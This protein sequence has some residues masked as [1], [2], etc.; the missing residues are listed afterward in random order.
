MLIP[1]VVIKGGGD[2]GTGVAHRLFR[3]AFFVVILELPQPRVIRRL[4]SFAEAVYE[5]E[6]V[7]EGVTARQLSSAPTKRP[8]FIPVLVDPE[9]AQISSIR[10][11]VIVDARMAKRN[12]GTRID[13][14]PLVIGLGPGFTARKDVHLVVETMRGHDLGRLYTKGSALPNTGIPASVEGYSRE[15]VLRAPTDGIFHALSNLGDQV[16]AGE[17]VAK[18][19]GAPLV[20]PIS[21]VLRGMLHSGLAVKAGDKVGDIDPRWDVDVRTISDKA[22]SIGGAVLEGILSFLPWGLE[23]VEG[24]K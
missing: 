7:V 21:G 12:L 16:N 17:L 18:V 9:G 24:I 13:E 22:R 2:L 4:V 23:E 6:W 15:R 20:A 5:K 1:R 19:D 10:P 14:A 3:S 11:H 8:D